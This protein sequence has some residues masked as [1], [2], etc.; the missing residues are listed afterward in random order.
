MRLLLRSDPADRRERR[1]SCAAEACLRH[2][3]A[4][5]GF[6]LHGE[7]SFGSSSPKY[8]I[9][10]APAR[11]GFQPEAAVHEQRRLC[12]KIESHETTIRAAAGSEPLQQRRDQWA[13]HHEISIAFL[14]TSV[15]LII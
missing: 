13:M 11:G 9:V 6:G 14:V 5:D 12:P 2:S 4:E 3:S 10:L 7:F 15:G 1:D 8:K